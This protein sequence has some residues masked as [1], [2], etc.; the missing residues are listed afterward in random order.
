[1]SN[2]IFLYYLLSLHSSIIFKSK[3]DYIYY[4]SVIQY[5]SKLFISQS[6]SFSLSKLELEN[7]FRL[8]KSE[9][10]FN[11]LTIDILKEL[12]EKLIDAV[13]MVTQQPSGKTMIKW[14]KETGFSSVKTTGSGHAE[15][16]QIFEKIPHEQ[17]PKNIKNVDELLV[18]IIK[19]IITTPATKNTGLI[20]AVK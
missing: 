19:N 14:L 10:S 6:L 2:F 17:H 9:I 8:H 4:V 7:I 13:V 16:K 20:T 5:E 11:G 1:M 12:S 3:I 18:P 15:A